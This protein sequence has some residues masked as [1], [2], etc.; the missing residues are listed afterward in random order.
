MSSIEI[1]YKPK[2]PPSP[3][4]V[5][6]A[7]FGGRLGL[8]GRSNGGLL[9]ANQVVRDRLGLRA[10]QAAGIV[11]GWLKLLMKQKFSGVGCGVWVQQSVL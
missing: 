4:I 2:P 9:V 8:F 5:S 11:L 7:D 6:L 3:A 10:Y 1:L